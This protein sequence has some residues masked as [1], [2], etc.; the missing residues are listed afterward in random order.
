MFAPPASHYI[1]LPES[2]GRRAIIFVDTEEEFDWAQPKRRDATSVETVR[3]LPIVH[4]QLRSFGLKPAYLID[5]PVASAPSSIAVLKS[6]LDAGECTIGAQLH[7]WVNPPFTEEVAPFNS[8]PGNLPRDLE[9]AKLRA[10]TEKLEESFG[11][12]PVVYRAGRYGIGPNTEALLD[13]LGYRMDV[14]VRPLFGYGDEG[15]P[16]FAG[17]GMAPYWTGPE[18]RLVEVPLTSAFIGAFRYLGEGAYNRAARIPH[19]QGLLARL[20]L[21]NRVALTPEGIPLDEALAAI[22]VLL[23]RDCRLFSI[24]FHSPSVEPGHTPYV[25]DQA[26][27]KRFYQWWDGVLNKLAKAGVEPATVEEVLAAVDATR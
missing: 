1:D 17:I 21:L 11:T 9:L 3:S 7:P 22:D 4:R 8:F 12:R 19:L 2:F 23:D 10:L 20:R 15:G 18:K 6:F 25:R 24:S 16:D 14:S 5:Y 26:D 13:M 27:L